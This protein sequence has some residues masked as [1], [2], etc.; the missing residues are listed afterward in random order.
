MISIVIPCLNEAANII[1]TLE[2][3]QAMRSRGQEIILVDGGSTDQTTSLAQPLVDVILHTAAGRARQMNTGLA[4]ARGDIVWFL[5]ADTLAQ[6]DMDCQIIECLEDSNAQWGHWRVRLSGS[7]PSLRLVETLMN[8]RSC[9][10]GIA[11]GDQGL[12][13]RT[14]VLRGLGG[15]PD[16]PLMEDVALSRRLKK[17]CGPLRCL[18]GPLITSSR[19]WESRGIWRTVLLMWR[20]RLAYAL[21]ADPKKLAALYR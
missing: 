17:F 1:P 16:I 7:Q 20:L 8:H 14:G 9:L 10:T 6:P 19:R 18:S 21:G 12:F 3:L 13:A 4:Q 11:T 5:H 2:A 15:Y